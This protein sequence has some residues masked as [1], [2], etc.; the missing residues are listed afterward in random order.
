[1]D[2]RD[3]LIALSDDARGWLKVWAAGFDEADAAK[4]GV[5]PINPLAWQLGHI[6]CAEDS[7]YGLYVA[8]GQPLADTA[9][10]NV[11]GAGAGPPASAAS[12][13]ALSELWGLLDAT[14]ARLIELVRRSGGQDFD[15][16]SEPANRYFRTLGQSI[17]EL[18]LHEN[19]HVGQ[20]AVLRKALGKPRIG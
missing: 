4:T 13:P 14:H 10:S 18:A 20:I 15:R 7:V 17:Y 2:L 16:P 19:Y 11:C 12:Y 5:A 8:G 3:T 1:M 9:L 6:A